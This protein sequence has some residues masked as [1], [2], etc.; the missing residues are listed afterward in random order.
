VARRHAGA[1]QELHLGRGAEPHTIAV[2]QRALAHALFVHEGAETGSAIPD[3]EA[4][5]AGL[6]HGVLTGDIL[7][8]EAQVLGGAAPD[9][10]AFLGDEM[11]TELPVL[12]TLEVGRDHRVSPLCRRRQRVYAWQGSGATV[13]RGCARLS[14]M[15]AL[16]AVIALVLTISGCAPAPAPGS[17]YADVRGIHMYYE[18][19]GVGRRV[20]LLLHG[21]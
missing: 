20:L 21:G 11:G 4:R 13:G 19:H 15:R 18:V 12:F 14:T 6:D 8:V 17:H 7:E 16:P 1:E 3:D 9:G 10:K 5:A 2:V